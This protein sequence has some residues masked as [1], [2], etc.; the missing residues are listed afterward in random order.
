M[1]CR[2]KK[3]MDGEDV[4]GYKI[5]VQCAVTG[6]TPG[7]A[8]SPKLAAS[9]G[10]NGG[11]PRKPHRTDKS[12]HGCSA[13]ASNDSGVR[14]GSSDD[15]ETVGETSG[16]TDSGPA[17][18]A[19]PGT[20]QGLNSTSSNVPVNGDDIVVCGP[21]EEIDVD[22]MEVPTKDVSTTSD[23]VSCDAVTTPS[24][25]ARKKKSQCTNTIKPCKLI[26]YVVSKSF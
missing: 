22:V 11:V 3:R 9:N 12:P 21:V 15:N 7:G 13:S 17:A 4:F 24:R 14:L 1:L 19:P 26:F 16:R 10:G 20:D 18:T 2:A 5:K 8:G 6:T 23:T 25:K